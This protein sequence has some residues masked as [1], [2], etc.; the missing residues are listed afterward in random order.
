MFTVCTFIQIIIEECKQILH[1]HLKLVWRFHTT[2]RGQIMVQLFNK[3]IQYQ[4]S[5]QLPDGV[6]HLNLKAFYLS[7]F[8]FYIN[9]IIIVCTT[10]AKLC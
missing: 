2:T 5:M 6:S 7:A 8:Q 9:I 3:T 10:L 4:L 1:K